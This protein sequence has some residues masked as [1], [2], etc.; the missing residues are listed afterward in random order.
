MFFGSGKKAAPPAGGSAAAGAQG[1]EGGG[2]AL[3]FGGQAEPSSG[4][5][6]SVIDLSGGD[7]PSTSFTTAA[8]Q[9]TAAG[10]QPR[11][12]LAPRADNGGGSS[13]SG[14]SGGAGQPGKAPLSLREVKHRLMETL[15]A[16]K[17][18]EGGGYYDRVHVEK[19]RSA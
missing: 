2:R 9:Q 16:I 8:S 10:P 12:V 15:K 1:V 18:A 6:G 5:A 3:S 14:S 11:Q 4:S 7:A 19:V 13:G 17:E